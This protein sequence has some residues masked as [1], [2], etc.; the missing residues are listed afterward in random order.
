MKDIEVEKLI[1][2][3]LKG[4]EDTLVLF[5]GNKYEKTLTERMKKMLVYVYDDD[6]QYGRLKI[7]D[8]LEIAM[9]FAKDFTADLMLDENREKEIELRVGKIM[10]ESYWSLKRRAVPYSETLKYIKEE[11]SLI[12]ELNKDLKFN[13]TKLF[14][15]CNDHYRKDYMV[16]DIVNKME[17][18]QSLLSKR[19]Y[20]GYSKKKEV[21]N[22]YFN[23]EVED[24]NEFW[25]ALQ[26]FKNIYDNM[27][28]DF[29]YKDKLLEQ[30]AYVYSA[31]GAKGDTPFEIFADA[32]EKNITINSDIVNKMEEDY[33]KLYAQEIKY[34]VQD[35]TNLKR[36]FSDLND[37]NIEV[38][39][40]YL[41]V[42][43]YSRVMSLSALQIMDNN[44]LPACIL[45]VN[46]MSMYNDSFINTCFHEMIHYV[47]GV[48]LNFNKCRLIYNNDPRYLILDECFT[49][50]VANKCSEEYLSENSYFFPINLGEDIGCIYDCTLDYLTE[51]F[52]LFGDKLLEIHLSQSI[53]LVS[54]KRMCPIEEIADDL[55]Q[56][57]NASKEER[58]LISD[59][60]KVSLGRWK[61]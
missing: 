6:F 39:Q 33:N 9:D 38:A 60:K 43:I 18:F 37:N 53:D 48:N 54:A 4:F 52:K 24:L 26:S 22:K 59:A 7:I 23:I 31:L 21:I 55:Y 1:K 51:V 11:L 44:H 56:I 2:K 45:F 5:C 25:C 10:L 29:A 36:I 50:Y 34:Q 47:G 13:T 41:N 30:R 8:L 58:K 40:E 57:Y 15:L 3:N 16:K 32:R 28:D 27:L 46:D 61:R 20:I 14:N 49:N 19:E 12:P 17:N 42:Y 35:H